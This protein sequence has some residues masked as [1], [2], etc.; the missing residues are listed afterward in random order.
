MKIRITLHIE[1]TYGAYKWVQR[2][3]EVKYRRRRLFFFFECKF[4]RT[5]G[6]VL[7]NRITFFIRKAEKTE[8][9]IC[10][11]KKHE[12]RPFLLHYMKY[13]ANIAVF[14]EVWTMN[15]NRYL[16]I[17]LSQHTILYYKKTWIQM[18][19]FIKLVLYVFFS[20]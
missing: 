18:H 13:L 19:T 10:E 15:N 9:K 7:F 1:R 16:C 14:Y 11:A 4:Q 3:N 8:E 2:R 12:M 17:S 20:F 5:A 6:R